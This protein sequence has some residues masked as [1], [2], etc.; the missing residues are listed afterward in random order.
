MP[1]HL[2]VVGRKELLIPNIDTQFPKHNNTHL[3][4]PET[5]LI[6]WLNINLTFRVHIHVPG[7][8]WLYFQLSCLFFFDVTVYKTNLKGLWNWSG[9]CCFSRGLE[10]QWKKANHTFCMYFTKD[11]QSVANASEPAFQRH[12]LTECS[13]AGEKG[14]EREINIWQGQE[15]YEL[16]PI[17]GMS[18][19][20]LSCFPQPDIT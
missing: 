19:L 3:C 16:Y 18:W 2:P 20:N 7:Q 17:P 9:Q 1:G 10:L 6:C 12:L 13:S 5:K 4:A 8:L 15:C 14:K 11:E